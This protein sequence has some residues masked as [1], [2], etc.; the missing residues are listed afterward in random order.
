MYLHVTTGI[1]GVL[2]PHEAAHLVASRAIPLLQQHSRLGAAVRL[3]RA[4][5][6]LLITR[7]LPPFSRNSARAE[8]AAHEEAGGGGR[9]G[10]SEGHL[11]V[12]KESCYAR[13]D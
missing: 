13:A 2:M 12:A 11:E 9:F 7:P 1:S 5:L 6:P 8:G 4:A 10:R 3:L